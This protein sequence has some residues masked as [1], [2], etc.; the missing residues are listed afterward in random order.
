[1]NPAVA[2]VSLGRRLAANHRPAGVNP[3]VALALAIYSRSRFRYYFEIKIT[4][5]PGAGFGKEN[6]GRP[7]FGQGGG[8]DE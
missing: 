3:T 2:F 8:I 6:A 4:V 7:W 1:M 5:K